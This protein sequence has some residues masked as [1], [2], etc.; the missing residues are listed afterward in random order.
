MNS[1]LSRAIAMTCDFVISLIFI[2]YSLTIV[3]VATVMCLVLAVLVVL[4]VASL[5]IAAAPFALAALLVSGERSG[6]RTDFLSDWVDD[7]LEGLEARIES[8]KWKRAP[9]SS[10]GMDQP[11]D[12]EKK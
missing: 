1:V 11:T 3:S 5:A 8:L 12:G 10:D 4:A 7:R 2:I 9:I 6:D